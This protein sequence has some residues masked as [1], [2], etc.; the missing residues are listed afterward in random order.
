MSI[1]RDLTIENVIKN[2]IITYCTLDKDGIFNSAVCIKFECIFYYIV[3][4]RHISCLIND[5]TYSQMSN[6]K[7]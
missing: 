2:K 5:N 1:L 7:H 3:T 6:Q 4:N